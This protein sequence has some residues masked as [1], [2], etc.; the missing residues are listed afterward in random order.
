[1]KKRVAGGENEIDNL[2]WENIGKFLRQAYAV[3][4]DMKAVSTSIS[5]SENKK[6]AMEDIEQLRKYAQAADLSA[7]KQ[8]GPGFVSLVD[9]M[10]FH[11]N[12]YFSALIDIPDEI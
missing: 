10:V 3:G 2:E 4:D 12:D 8:D 1:M 5:N 11:V 7:S 9:K 6:R